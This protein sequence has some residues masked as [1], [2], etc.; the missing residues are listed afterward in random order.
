[1]G[2][3]LEFIDQLLS[4]WK[5]TIAR[6]S[7]NL[8]DLQELPAYQ[9]LTGNAGFPSMQLIGKTQAQ[10][11]PAL[12]AMN[13]LF[14]HFDL[15]LTTC[16]RATS[17]RQ[18]V[19]RFL[20]AEAK[21]Q[22]I[23]NLLLGRSIQLPAQQVPLAQRGLLSAAETTCTLSPNE[24]LEAMAETFEVAK[25]AV[26][27][28][29]HAWSTLE[30]TLWQTETEISSL[31]RVADALGQGTLTELVAVRQ[32]LT[33]LRDRVEQDPLGVQDELE[34]Q[35]Q[36]LLTPVKRRLDSLA[37]Q[38]T[39]IQSLLSQGQVR[40]QQLTDLQQQ[41]IAA[42]TERQ[43]K[44]VND[45]SVPCPLAQEQLDALQHWF[46]RLETKFTEGVMNPVQVGLENWTTKVNE[47]IATE[48]ATLAANRAP[49]DLRRELR[50]RLDALQAKA[51]ARGWVEDSTL[52]DLA[53]QAKHL[54][55]IRPTPLDQ[56]TELITRYE[57][58]LNQ[59]Q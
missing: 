38:R 14:Q 55:Y 30:P 41:A 36:G 18:Q 46:S 52:S 2:V 37:Q 12:E 13:S 27:A 51:L 42:F 4:D 15:L 44:L 3:T 35:I 11:M 17:L 8:I 29:D 45:P 1:M 58:H 59:R 28:V 56:A 33:A 19:P 20:G 40:L 49:L 53:Q 25:A 39:Y 32:Q 43:E 26:L 50:G 7:Q 47:A 9:R 34:Q 57:K 16:D 22:E 21:L 54:L 5:A 24:L 6:V 10:V 31:H 23:E 48:Q